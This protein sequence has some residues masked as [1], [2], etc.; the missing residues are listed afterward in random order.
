GRPSDENTEFDFKRTDHYARSKYLA[1]QEVL[2]YCKKGLPAIILNP[3][4]VIGQRDGTGSHKKKA[5][6]RVRRRE[7]V[8]FL[9]ICFQVSTSRA[10]GMMQA[11]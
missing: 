7:L 10:C 11:A 5:L 8:D 1:E 3:A 6:R 4:I 2:K 9:R